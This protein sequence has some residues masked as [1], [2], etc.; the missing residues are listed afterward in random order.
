M[1]HPKT[2]L[3][4]TAHKNTKRFLKLSSLVLLALRNFNESWCVQ[5]FISPPGNKVWFNKVSRLELFIFQSQC[6]NYILNRF[7]ITDM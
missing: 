6:K 1:V 7:L 3:M 2:S 4:Q 5:V